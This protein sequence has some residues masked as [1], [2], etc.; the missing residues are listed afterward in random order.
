MRAKVEDQLRA[1]CVADTAAVRKTWSKMFG[2]TVPKNASREFLQRAMAHELQ[3]KGYGGLKAATKRRLVQ[4]AQAIEKDP[5]YC[6]GPAPPLKP[7]TKLIR[8]WQDRRIEVMVLETGFAFE[9]R[10]YGSLSKIAAE[11]TGTR[12]SGPVF[13]GLKKT[14]EARATP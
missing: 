2:A 4:I 12:W 5:D 8:Q 14:G 9:G 11:V 7:G 3:V 6:P 10:T 1:L 13:F